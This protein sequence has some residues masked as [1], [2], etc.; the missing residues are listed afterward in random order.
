MPHIS[1]NPHVN[2]PY[3]IQ[4]GDVLYSDEELL[5]AIQHSAAVAVYILGAVDRIGYLDR[6]N[7][8]AVRIQN[9]NYFRD[10][11]QLVVHYFLDDGSGT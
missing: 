1:S 5:W 7:L 9:H 2:N 6:F 8:F 4:A 10:D 11:I 3:N